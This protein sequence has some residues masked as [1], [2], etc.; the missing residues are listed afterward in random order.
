MKKIYQKY[1]PIFFVLII[2]AAFAYG[3]AK[4]IIF[5]GRGSQTDTS[6]YASDKQIIDSLVSWGFEITWLPNDTLKAATFDPAFYDGK[7]GIFIN[8]TS[9]SKAM[10]RYGTTDD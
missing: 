3:Q 8:E 9:D 4:N 6:V 5:I 1:L 2:S 10:A 7:D